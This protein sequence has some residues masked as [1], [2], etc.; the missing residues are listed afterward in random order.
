MGQSS[1]INNAALKLNTSPYFFENMFIFK[2]LK[3][4]TLKTLRQITPAYKKYNQKPVVF[5]TIKNPTDDILNKKT[6][7]SGTYANKSK[8]ANKEVRGCFTL[9]QRY[10]P[11]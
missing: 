3:E 9:Q 10:T 5:N 6:P 4:K 8:L 11:F 7:Y 1:S 2:A